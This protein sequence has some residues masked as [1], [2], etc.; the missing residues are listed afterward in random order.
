MNVHGNFILGKNEN[1]A[2]IGFVWGLFGYIFRISVILRYFACAVV[3]T[4]TRR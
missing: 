3:S 2:D 1:C 4:T